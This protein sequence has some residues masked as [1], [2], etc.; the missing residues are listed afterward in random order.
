MLSFY[1]VCILYLVSFSQMLLKIWTVVYSGSY[2]FIFC[3]E[4][5]SQNRI[6]NIFKEIYHTIRSDGQVRH[7]H[8]NDTNVFMSK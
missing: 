3:Q 4:K 5:V 6:K 8:S 7:R 2:V 1:L